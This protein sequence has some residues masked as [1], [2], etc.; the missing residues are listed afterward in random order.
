MADHPKAKEIDA[1]SRKDKVFKK[2]IFDTSFLETFNY[3][4]KDEEGQEK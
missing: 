2:G 1:F 4:T 3:E